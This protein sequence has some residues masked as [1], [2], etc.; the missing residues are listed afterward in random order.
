MGLANLQGPLGSVGFVFM[1]C[2]LYKIIFDK[3]VLEKVE[4]MLIL[5]NRSCCSSGENGGRKGGGGEDH[6]KATHLG[7]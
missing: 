7:P 4:K 1:Y 5:L 6:L 3:W 2:D